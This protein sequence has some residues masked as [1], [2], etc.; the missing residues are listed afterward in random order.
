MVIL[1][2]LVN[3]IKIFQIPVLRFVSFWFE[4]FSETFE[5]TVLPLDVKQWSDLLVI[6]TSI[7]TG[8]NF[9]GLYFF[10]LTNMKK[11]VNQGYMK[12]AAFMFLEDSWIRF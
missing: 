1:Y 10:S 5:F 11:N 4:L 3:I 6:Y 12:A 2:E 9:G 8:D 7:Y